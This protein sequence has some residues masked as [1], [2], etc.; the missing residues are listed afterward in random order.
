[1]SFI[2]NHDVSQKEILANYAIDDLS[3]TLISRKNHLTR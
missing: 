2:S 3:C 1:M